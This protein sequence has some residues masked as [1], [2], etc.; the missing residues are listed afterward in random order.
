LIEAYATISRAIS[1]LYVD[2]DADAERL[3]GEV[4]FELQKRSRKVGYDGRS[5]QNVRPLLYT[6]G[7]ALS[8]PPARPERKG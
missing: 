1:A 6:V 3:V 4:A 8:P 5:G 2:D 7:V